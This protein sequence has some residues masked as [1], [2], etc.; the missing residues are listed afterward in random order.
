MYWKRL[1]LPG[2]AAPGRIWC[3]YRLRGQI[4]VQTLVW[5]TPCFGKLY[6]IRV[7]HLKLNEKPPDSS[8]LKSTLFKRR[9]SRTPR[10]YTLRVAFIMG[11]C[12][13]G[14]LNRC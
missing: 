9:L 11:F 5:G 13:G 14:E 4:C 12:S 2:Y 3:T 10:L 1:F 6:L 7:N 8:R